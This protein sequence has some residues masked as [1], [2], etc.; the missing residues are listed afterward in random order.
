MFVNV[1]V[2]RRQRHSRAQLDNISFQIDTRILMRQAENLTEQ[3]IEVRSNLHRL[4]PCSCS[5]FT[6]AAL[7]VPFACATGSSVG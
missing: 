3:S 7:S 4:L 2:K 5:S 1:V 6:Y